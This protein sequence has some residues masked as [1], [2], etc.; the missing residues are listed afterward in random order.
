MHFFSL[1]SQLLLWGSQQP[2]V[3]TSLPSCNSG[4]LI[5][6]HKPAPATVTETINVK[7]AGPTSG[8]SA[9][10]A[11]DIDSATA[12]A[13]IVGRLSNLYLLVEANASTF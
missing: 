12:F 8:T 2:F 5:A 7:N 9:D 10:P 11:I 6:S 1:A 3:D 4:N 13:L